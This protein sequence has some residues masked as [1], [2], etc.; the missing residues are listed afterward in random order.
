VRSTEARS[1][2]VLVVVSLPGGRRSS[3][4]KARD[5]P[6]QLNQLG[7]FRKGRQ[8]DRLVVVTEP[9]ITDTATAAKAPPYGA[10]V[11][12]VGRNIRSG[13]HSVAER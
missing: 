2:T 10:P 3:N 7:S 4:C 1:R 9:A 11:V 13:A 12:S 8:S 5:Q 6:D